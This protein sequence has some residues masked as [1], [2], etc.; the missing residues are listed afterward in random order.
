MTTTSFVSFPAGF[1]WGAST[2]S[3]QVEGGNTRND[4]WAF[5]QQGRVPDSSGDACDHYHRYESDFDLAVEL[6]HTAHR[7]SIEWSR[8]EP[9]PGVFDAEEIEHYVRVLQ[10]LKRR[11]LVTFVTLHHFTNPLWFSQAGGWTGKDAATSFERYVTAIAP[12]IAA[13]VDYWITINEPTQV[14]FAGYLFGEWPPGHRWD[15]VGAYRQLDA[16][17]DAH[18]AAARAIKRVEPSAHVGYANQSMNWRCNDDTSP[19]QR[20]VR[21]FMDDFTN[22][23]FCDRVADSLDF[24]GVQYYHTL[25]VGWRPYG[26]GHL[27]GTVTTDVGWDIVPEGLEKVVTECWKRYRIPIFITENGLADGADKRRSD[28]IT[29]H[30]IALAKAIDGGADVRGYL[31]WSL[32]DNFEWAEGF[33]P[34][35][36]LVE[37]DYAT[38]QRTPRASAHLYREIIAANGFEKAAPV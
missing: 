12:E 7:L 30:L 21:D 20:M 14:A 16:M 23:R 32:M 3:H 33:A 35:F 22:R 15:L 11:G 8:V 18:F 26:P 36:G 37:V 27:S 19:W 17:A 24:I 6:G 38:Q 2:S 29:D 9:Q 31:H 34:R 1:L 5:E 25:R 28:F 4:W 13:Y 10:A